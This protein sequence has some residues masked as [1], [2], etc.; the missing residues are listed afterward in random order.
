MLCENVLGHLKCTKT[1][2]VCSTIIHH[3]RKKRR[4]IPDTLFEFTTI[5]GVYQVIKIYILIYCRQNIINSEM[6]DASSVR[7]N[8]VWF[9]LL[10]QREYDSWGRG[11]G[12]KNAATWRIQCDIV[13]DKFSQNWQHKIAQRR[14]CRNATK[15]CKPLRIRKCCDKFRGARHRVRKDIEFKRRL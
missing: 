6:W 5:I 4:H 3:Y 15:C 8:R 11:K 13:P 2:K 12:R 9:M 1:S 14:H 7:W 10:F